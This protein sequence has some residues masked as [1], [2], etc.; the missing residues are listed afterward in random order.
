MA[1]L[2]KNLFGVKSVLLIHSTYVNAVSPHSPSSPVQQQ[3]MLKHSSLDSPQLPRRAH[4]SKVCVLSTTTFPSKFTLTSVLQN[5][6]TFCGKQEN[7]RYSSIPWSKFFQ[8]LEFNA[9]LECLLL[10][11]FP[12]VHQITISW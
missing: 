3:F 5:A 7:Y 10:Y 2:T 9:L 8:I 1:T 4:F 11:Y 12:A 6:A